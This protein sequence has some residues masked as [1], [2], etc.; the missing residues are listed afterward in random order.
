M[1]RKVIWRNSSLKVL[2]SGEGNRY[3]DPGNLRAPNE[4]NPKWHTSRH[5]VIEMVEVKDQE[6]PRSCQRKI[7]SSVQ[8]K[9]YQ[10]S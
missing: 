3:S 4:T 10:N 8:G 6:N 5:I 1:V 9:T 7:T 2:Q